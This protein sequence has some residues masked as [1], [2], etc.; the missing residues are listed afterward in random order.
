MNS[1]WTLTKLGDLLNPISRT[2][3]VQPMVEHDLLGIRLDGKGPFLRESK[4]GSSI[5]AS[6]LNRVAAG[7]FI[8]SRL[9]AWRGAFGVIGEEL[10]GSFVS[11]EFPT[12]RP[13]QDRLDINF[14]RFWFRL[15]ETLKRVEA[16]CTGSTPLTRNRYKENYFL[17]LE[18]SLP[19]L[20]E[21]RRIVAKIEELAAKIEEARRLRE[22]AMSNVLAL[23]SGALKIA[24][25][26]KRD[27]KIEK[28]GEFCEPPQYGYTASAT[29]EP[30]GPRLLRITDI[31]DG[32]VNWDTVPFCPC[33]EPQK[34]LLQK[35]DLVF[36]RTGATTGKS[37]VIGECPEAIFASYL[38]R[39]RVSRA[40]NMDYLYWFFQSPYYWSQIADKST[41][42]GQPNFNGK[43]LAAI[44][45]PIAPT[46][47]QRRIVA[48]LDGLQAKVDALKKLQAHTAA[49]LDALLPAILDRAF[50]GEL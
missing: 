43:K 34:Y 8:Y 14:L 27:W 9:F 29:T 36:A 23:M 32:K 46:D 42:T 16:D 21:Q 24:F 33:P 40:V 28:V 44:Q 22:E 7:D 13:D 35:N 30:V 25:E 48:Y 2:T 18:I 12:F 26:P 45:V 17:K 37:F 15:P 50:K 47:E 41:G 39:L 5:S 3:M 6:T 19:P 4:V 1:H 49:E 10:D 20:P 11:N 38:I 31:Q